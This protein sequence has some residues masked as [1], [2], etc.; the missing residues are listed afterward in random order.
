MAF[1]KEDE[2][3]DYKEEIPAVTKGHEVDWASIAAD[4][5]AFHNAKGV[6]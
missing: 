3:W 4:V 6:S 5:L 2:Y 1:Y